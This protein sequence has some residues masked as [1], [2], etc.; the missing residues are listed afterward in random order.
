MSDRERERQQGKRGI[1]RGIDIES[2]EQDLARRHRLI[3]TAIDLMTKQLLHTVA[4]AFIFVS[5]TFSVQ[6]QATSRLQ[7]QRQTLSATKRVWQGRQSVRCPS[8]MHTKEPP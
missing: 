8:S 4:Y 5:N 1:K 2:V 6:H 7:F 3:G